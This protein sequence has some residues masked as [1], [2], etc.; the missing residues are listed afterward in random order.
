M[1][2]RR[3]RRSTRCERTRRESLATFKLPDDVVVLDELPLT[4]MEKVDRRALQDRQRT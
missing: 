2:P 3:R 4:P 1:I